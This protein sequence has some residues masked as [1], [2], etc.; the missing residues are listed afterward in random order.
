MSIQDKNEWKPKVLRVHTT[1]LNESPVESLARPSLLTLPTFL[2]C[3]YTAEVKCQKSFFDTSWPSEEL[4]TGSNRPQIPGLLR[5][6]PKVI[7]IGIFLSSFLSSSIELQQSWSQSQL[8]QGPRHVLGL[9]RKLNYPG[10]TYKLHT[11]ENQPGFKPRTILCEVTTH[12]T[13]LH[14][15]QNWYNLCKDCKNIQRVWD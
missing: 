5:Q 6:T 15:V 10:R 14:T 7:Y 8:S 4:V 13:S 1:G 12:C 2:G 9:G 3:F 11:E